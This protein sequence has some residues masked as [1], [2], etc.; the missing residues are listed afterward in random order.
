MPI[1]AADRDR[2]DVGRVDVV[3]VEQ[4]LALDARARDQLVHAVERAQERRLAAAGGADQRR[5]LVRLDR[6]VD[7]L[8]RQ[9]VAVVQVQVRRP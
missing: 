8:D 3:A 5:D 7:V 1:C 6:H 4:D 2:V 9:E